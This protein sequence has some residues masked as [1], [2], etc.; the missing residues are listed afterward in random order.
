MKTPK[1]NQ[2]FLPAFRKA[3]LLWSTQTTCRIAVF[4]LAA[5]L[6]VLAAWNVFATDVR[7]VGNLSYNYK[8][9]D[10]DYYVTLTS[11]QIRN[12]TSGGHSGSLKM[13][14]WAL[15]AP[16]PGH[17]NGVKLASHWLDI[18][19]GGQSFNDVNSGWISMT[20]PP[21]GRWCIAM[22]LKEYV[23]GTGDG[24]VVRN[25]FNFSNGQ[26]AAGAG[27]YGDETIVGN[28]TYSYLG[29]FLNL[30]LD[31]VQNICNLGLS[32]N[33]TL[34]LWA[35]T[36]PYG[37][38]TGFAY[39]MGTA[40]LDRMRGASEL[41][42]ISRT[43]PFSQPP[44]GTYY[45]TLTLSDDG[46]GSRQVVSSL[47]F[48]NS[49]TIKSP[50]APTV[51]NA[52]AVNSSSFTASW[53]SINGATGYLL[54]VSDSSMFTTLLAG[55]ENL[56]VGN[57]LSYQ[58]SGLN[59]NTTYYYRVRAYNN[60]A[61]SAP[62][63]SVSVTTIPPGPPATPGANPPRDVSATSFTAN[64]NS[65]MGAAGYQLDISTNSGFRTYLS[66]HQ[67]LDVGTALDYEVTG[68]SPGKVYYY[69]VRA[70]N[71][72]GVSDNARPVIA[73]TLPASGSIPILRM[74]NGMWEI[75][76]SGKDPGTAFITFAD[77]NTLSG[78][79]MTLKSFGWFT[80]EGTWAVD[81]KGNTLAIY[82]QSA[83]DTPSFDATLLGKAN[84]SKT[85]SVKVTNPKGVYTMSGAPSKAP[86][87]DLTGTWTAKVT[88][89]KIKSTQ[90]FNI[91]RSEDHPA[92]FYLSSPETGD[93]L[94]LSGYAIVTSKGKVGL[95]Y[96]TYDQDGNGI[97]MCSFTGTLNLRKQTGTLSGVT[98]HG[99]TLRA[100]LIR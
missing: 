22:L 45:I 58:V 81:A 46:S 2:Y 23:G 28:A 9:A 7:F 69:R 86:A 48:Q 64:W 8:Y 80:L 74:P 53:N 96:E 27:N 70:Y 55:Y 97:A 93:Y 31:K 12:Y 72:A 3:S 14:L 36:D 13:E 11:A 32:G 30:Y 98:D 95:C 75:T 6:S 42:A 19:Y 21:G 16:Y 37:S 78:Y 82:T 85:L 49:L 76:I 10:P 79:G 17:N 63:V 77:D 90:T 15:N 91:N 68:L 41:T 66:G 88:Q 33:L 47:T 26:R 54:D 83:E 56:D 43:V 34:D 38:G 39:L 92:L 84:N 71:A 50:L 87:P 59:P 67:S 25:W 100:N 5:L 20:T 62:S 65:S 99:A 18:L 29:T 73:A 40:S 24:Y 60:S 35:T 4:R 51:N 89:G 61:S 44:D 57:N 1:P 52:T 94:N